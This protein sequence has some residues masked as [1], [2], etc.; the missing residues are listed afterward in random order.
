M[1][2]RAIGFFLVLLTLL[3][4]LALSSCARGER[5]L[6]GSDIVI[7]NWFM[8]YDV[9]TFQPANDLEVRTLVH[10]RRI[11]NEHGFRM[12]YR[13][14]SSW[15][16]MLQTAIMSTMAGS[17]A[18]SAF[19]LQPSWAMT[20][21]RQNLIAPMPDGFDFSPKTLGDGRV[22]WNQ[23]V[24]N[25]F[26][27]DDNTYALSV[28]YGGSLQ[29]SVVFF[30]KRLFREAGLDPQLP[31]N[32]Q[33]DGTWT[34]DSFLSLAIQLTRD[35]DNDGI[36][37]TWAMPMDFSSAILDAVIASN[38]ANFVDRNPATG[39][40]VNATDRP[41]FLEALQFI[42]RLRDE[43]VMKPSQPGSHWTWFQSAFIDGQ[44]AMLIDPLFRKNDLRGMT[45]D[46]GMVMVPR[47]PRA[48]NFV[49]YT[50]EHVIV[51][52]STFSQ[53]EV[54]NIV[55][56]IDLWNRPVDETLYGWQD[57]YWHVFRDARSVTETMAILRDPNLVT[58]K[59]YIMIPGLS[60]GD[61]AWEMWGHDGDPAQL[62]EA[63]SLAWNS[64]I[65]DVN[66]DLAA[67]VLRNQN[68]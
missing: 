40:F 3:L 65:A 34:W 22:D 24:R 56:A 66:A 64:L 8:N 32:M 52:P 7:G 12:S 19:L 55:T 50:F 28:G 46:W 43:G 63:V 68:E 35:T 54:A 59:Y 2:N 51:I 42:M 18:A 57:A 39:M 14:I 16:E 21:H 1:Q 26:T 38:G 13:N 11:L 15:S 25:L 58:W 20:L 36:M 10:R 61:I 37:D 5:A 62:I 48:D 49:V 9:D 23:N 29:A 45:D 31:F 27:F 33:R 17:P 53:A 4:T 30:N 60:L 67:A 41:E 44:V 47:G 6:E